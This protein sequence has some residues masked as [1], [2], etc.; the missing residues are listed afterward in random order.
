M[1]IAVCDTFDAMLTERPY[2]HATDAKT[3]LEEIKRKSG[4]QFDPDIVNVMLECYN[5]GKLQC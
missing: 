3:S 4:T 5:S 1:I 2:Q